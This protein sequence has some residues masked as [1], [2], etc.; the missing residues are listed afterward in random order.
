[1]AVAT[2]TADLLVTTL[3]TRAQLSTSSAALA[4]VM[5]VVVVVVVVDAVS[6]T[7]VVI[8]LEHVGGGGVVGSFDTIVS[9]GDTPRGMALI[10]LQFYHCLESD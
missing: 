2:V 10:L 1:M 6:L 3:A 8:L 4:M 9:G 5:L 7:G